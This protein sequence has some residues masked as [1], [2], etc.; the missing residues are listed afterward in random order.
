MNLR[1]WRNSKS[2]D[3]T[4]AAAQLGISQPSVSRIENGEQF[5]SAETIEKMERLSDGEITVADLHAV[6][7]EARRAREGAAA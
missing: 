7:T 5:P 3:T 2:L 4:E 1:E 6:W